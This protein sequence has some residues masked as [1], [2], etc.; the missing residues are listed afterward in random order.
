[1]ATP[2]QIDVALDKISAEIAAIDALGN[3]AWEAV[4]KDKKSKP[5]RW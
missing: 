5:R 3:S 1:M 4:A 2:S